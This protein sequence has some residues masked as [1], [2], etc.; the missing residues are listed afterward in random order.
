[1]PL[2]SVL[3]DTLITKFMSETAAKRRQIFEAVTHTR[4]SISLTNSIASVQRACLGP[5]AIDRQASGPQAVSIEDSTA[6]IHGSRGQREPVGDQVR[7]EPFIIAAMAK[8][9]LAPNPK[10]NWDKWVGDY[11]LVRDAIEATYP[12][13][14]KDFNKRMFEPGGFP[15]PLG[16]RERKWKTATGKA[17]FT[18]TESLSTGFVETPAVT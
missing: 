15:R 7:S 12:D 8:T 11:A 5:I 1:L 3:L 9:T 6:C 18:V 16:A 14:F 10:I 17:N 4:A 2:C 13:Q